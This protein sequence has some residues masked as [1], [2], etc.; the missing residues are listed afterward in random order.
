MGD[1]NS[2]VSTHITLNDM[3][4]HGRKRSREL[5]SHKTETSRMTLGGAPG[6]RLFLLG[7]LLV[8]GFVGARGP[9]NLVISPSHFP[10]AMRLFSFIQKLR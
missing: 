4:H 9:L 3:S 8:L 6:G 1:C 7:G 2:W 10:I 5:F